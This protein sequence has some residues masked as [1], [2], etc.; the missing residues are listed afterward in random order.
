MSLTP[1]QQT[2][3]A[4][5][6]NVLVVAGAGTGKT[7]TLV[8]RC[9]SCLF[10][11]H[12]PASLDEI[13]MVTFTEAAAADMRQRIRARLEDKLVGHSDALRWSE[14]LALFDTAHIGTLHSFCLKLVRQH[15]YELELDP[16]LTVLA[17]E[18]AKLLADETLEDILLA[19]Y[20]GKT[21]FAEAVQQLIQTQ[22]RGWDQPIRT[23]VL[24]LHQYTQTLRDPEG[25]FALQLA[26]FESTE[27]TQWRSWLVEGMGDWRNRW[28]PVLRGKNPENKKAAE[29]A[30]ILKELP[31]HPSR[32]QYANVLEQVHAAS[33]E[34]PRGKKTEWLKPLAGFFE[35]AAFLASLARVS[36]HSDPLTEDWNWVRVQM[37][38]LLNLAKEFTA[39]FARAKRELGVVDFHDLEQH[40]LRVLWDRTTNQ[41]TAVARQW[42]NKLRFVFVDEYQD[43]NDAQDAILKALSREGAAANRFLVGDVKQSIYRFRLADPHI[44]QNYIETWHGAEGRAIPLVDN[45]R[46]HE[47]ILKFVNSFFGTLMQREV[48][49]VP[50]GEE[51]LLRFG[52]PENRGAL[53]L[54]HDGLGRAEI[55]LRVKGA[56]G[57]NL[58]SEGLEESTAAWTE[59]M[60]LEESGKEARLIALRLRELKDGGHLIWDES[61]KGMRPVGWGD[62]AVLLRSPAGKAESYARE[63]ARLGVPLL[64][65]RSGFYQSMEIT[66]LLSLLQLL[67]NPLQ[68]MPALAVL[69]SPLVG[70]SL[71]ELTAIRLGLPKG[72]IWAAL[73]RYHEPGGGDSGWSKADRFLKNFAA[74]RRLTRQVSLSRCLEAVLSETHYAAW[75]LTQPRGEQRHANVQRLLALAQQFDQFQ[76][77]GLSRFLR[78]IEAQ[79]AAETEPEVAGV[80]QGDSVAFMSIHQS[81]GLEFP[82]VVVADLGKP[83][84]FSDLRAEIIL[85]EKYGLCPQIKPPHTGRRYPSLPYW[86]A[87]Q[88][89]I[90]ELLGEELRLLYV[91]MTRARDTLI[92]TGNVAERK[93]K[94]QQG[95]T[96]DLNATLLMAARNGLD[97]VAA[98]FGTTS[99]SLPAPPSG[100]N[101]FIHWTIYD[102]LDERLLDAA[103]QRVDVEAEEPVVT[104][105]T[106]SWQ[107]LYK[108]LAWQYPHAAATHEP[109]KTSVSLLRRRLLDEVEA[110]ARPLFKS[111]LGS[112]KSGALSS[113]TGLSD[114]LSAAEI[115]TAHHTFLR[116][117]SLKRT[118]TVLELEQEARRMLEE[119][120]L[121][122]EEVAHLDLAALAA[123]WQSDMGMEIVRRPNQV[124]RELQ[125]TARF[126][127]HELH[128]AG[129][130]TP[131]LLEGEFVSVQGIADLAVLLPKEIWLID[132]KTD[133]FEVSALAEKVKSYEPQ[134]RLYA[135]A[136][137]R[138]YHRP[139][140]RLQLYFLAIQQTVPVEPVGT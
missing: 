91:A 34:W 68:D 139:V 72:H 18:E 96:T 107:K 114:G 59:M 50:Y 16:Q 9:L 48:G 2:A 58:V 140:N 95:E 135:L 55:H 99:G 92:L 137:G 88:R 81:K 131:G 121:S 102:D 112:S 90:Q 110:E 1:A 20:A 89:Q 73:Q 41:P 45:F 53:S 28:L 115:G 123:F 26:M 122:Q 54:A 132:F 106:G 101:M 56:T 40:A 24:R 35:E 70:M 84:N 126:S 103:T 39:G 129:A 93:F 65:A 118:Q 64:V 33:M 47:S 74:W 127:P 82:V 44:F 11:D 120:T 23:L 62:M 32:D 4:A 130:R 51:A 21:G 67:D 15:F 52:D 117:V 42:R 12:P 109:A 87:R 80:S 119:G 75:L 111:R 60:N 94:E 27:A 97:W 133:S 98:W 30:A 8:E 6:G 113:W 124:R 100:E 79:Q 71:D 66:D 25:W 7:S 134:L 29:C 63:F 3:I 108:R 138:V 49:G 105:G 22:G 36:G 37:A 43:I 38:T 136:L 61:S 69:H 13:L 76:R 14:Q 31:D 85:D 57:A 125:F 116:L 77:Q 128:G 46:S 17:E 83:F 104:L 10:D 5:R 86:L 19:H 78:L